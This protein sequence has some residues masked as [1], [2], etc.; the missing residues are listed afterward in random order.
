MTAVKNIQLIF[1][2]ISSSSAMAISMPG[3]AELIQYARTIV[4]DTARNAAM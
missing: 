1:G 3:T 4:V 2:V